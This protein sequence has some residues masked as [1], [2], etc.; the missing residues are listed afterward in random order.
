[1][2]NKKNIL[3]VNWGI[4]TGEFPLRESIKLGKYNIY[5]ACTEKPPVWVRKL[6]NKSRIIET[7]PYNSQILIQD[8]EE[9]C[10]KR[11]IKFPNFPAIGDIVCFINTA[12]YMM[13]FYESQAHLFDLA[14]NL[15]ATETADGWHYDLDRY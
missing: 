3:I 11:K 7:N 6:F 12:G 9:Y 15:F 13:H 14:R 10:L 5:L 8:V 4:D 2:R 1:M